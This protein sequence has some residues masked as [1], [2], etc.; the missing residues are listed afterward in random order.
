MTQRTSALWV[1]YHNMVTLVKHF[2]R[3]ERMHDYNM[4]LSAVALTLPY[5]ATS[6]RGQYVKALR[7]YLEQDAIFEVKYGDF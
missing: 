1:T 4:H 7:L 6:G 2:I 3:S 5:F